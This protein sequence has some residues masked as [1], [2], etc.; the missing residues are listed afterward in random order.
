M[1]KLLFITSLVAITIWIVGVFFTNTG[2]F[3]HFFL[4][5]SILLYIR[6]LMAPATAKWKELF[7]KYK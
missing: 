7:I 5:L 2:R 3:I 4:A 6:S 1:K